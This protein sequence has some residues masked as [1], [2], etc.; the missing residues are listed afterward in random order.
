M[1][2]NKMFKNNFMK[3]KRGAEEV[4]SLY[5]LVILFIAAGGIIGMVLIF[6]GNPYD[7]RD[8]EASLLVD[9]IANCI[10]Y[11][12]KINNLIISDGETGEFTFS[13]CHLNFSYEEDEYFY[14]ISIYKFEDLE[15]YFF[16]TRGGNLNLEASYAINEYSENLPVGVERSFYSLDNVS[17]QYIIKIL[18][19]V[20][21]TEQ[22]V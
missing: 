19:V 8:I 4:M 9:K 21:K 1:A 13:N 20:R 17:N 11:G 6:Y 14:K 2:T 18:G 22:N 7:I 3:R 10:S 12:G 15:N 16:E 5:W